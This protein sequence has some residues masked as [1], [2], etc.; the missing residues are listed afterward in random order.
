MVDRIVEIRQ[1]SPN[2]SVTRPI[3]KLVVGGAG[4]PGVEGDPGTPGA[5]GVDGIDGESAYQIAVDNGFVGTEAQWLASLQGPQ[6]VGG[7]E[8]YRHVQGFSTSTWIIIHNKGFYLNW[9]VVDSGGSPV[10][11]HVEDVSTNETHISFMVNDI[12]AAFAG[13]AYGT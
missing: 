9:R 4:A 6:G 1:P 12:P 2:V 7:N 13:E 3:Q 5:P 8:P 10:V 11:G